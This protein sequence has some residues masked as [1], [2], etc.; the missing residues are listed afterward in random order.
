[1]LYSDYAIMSKLM[2]TEMEPIAAKGD[3]TMSTQRL[4]V[5]RPAERPS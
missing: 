1:M 2:I 3:I 4:D 5:L